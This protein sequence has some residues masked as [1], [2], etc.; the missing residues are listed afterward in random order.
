MSVA[1]DKAGR[2]NVPFRVDNLFSGIIDFAHRGNPTTRD[3]KV[4]AIARKSRP[5]DDGA[6]TD[7]DIVGHLFLLPSGGRV[8]LEGV[9]DAC[10][11]FWL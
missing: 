1:V 10:P 3:C 9:A 7:N 4:T 2:D 6:V 11:P 5:I 8:P